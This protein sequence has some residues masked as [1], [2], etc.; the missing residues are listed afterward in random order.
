[1][2]VR[3]RQLESYRGRRSVPDM[4]DLPWVAEEKNEVMHILYRR[5]LEG[6]GV[7]RF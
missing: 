7:L 5:A 1:M 4:W 2:R 3:L 6:M